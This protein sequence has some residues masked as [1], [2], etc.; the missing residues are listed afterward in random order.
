GD[1]RGPRG[2]R[3]PRHHPDR[4]RL[5]RLVHHASARRRIRDRERPA[6]PV[7]RAGPRT[8]APRRR[9]RPALTTAPNAAT[10]ETEDRYTQGTENRPPERPQTPRTANPEKPKTPGHRDTRGDP[11]VPHYAPRTR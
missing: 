1:G 7:R 11:E 2:A 4:P 8:R 3:P 10:R 6:A 9:G 5:P